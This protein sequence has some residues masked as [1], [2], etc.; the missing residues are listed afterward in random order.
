MIA[1]VKCCQKVKI[2]KDRVYENCPL[3]E[4]DQDGEA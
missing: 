4:R 3:G 1:N 2:K